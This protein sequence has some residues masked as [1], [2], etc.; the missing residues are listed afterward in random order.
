[1][2]ED[3]ER[4]Y[5]EISA[6][7]IESKSPQAIIEFRCGESLTQSQLDSLFLDWK[8][9]DTVPAVR[10]SRIYFILE[11]YGMRPGPRLPRVAEKMAK[12]LHPEY[13]LIQ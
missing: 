9:L 8:A 5:L 3:D 6:E 4:P 7:I 11:S 12:F 10:N 1:M 13:E 2:F